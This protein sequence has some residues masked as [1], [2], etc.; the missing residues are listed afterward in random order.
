MVWPT[1]GS[2]TA[3]KQNRTEQNLPRCF[4]EM[5]MVI[6]RSLLFQFIQ[7]R[8]MR[9]IYLPSEQQLQC[10]R[11]VQA[12]ALAPNTPTQPCPSERIR[13][14]SETISF[15]RYVKTNFDQYFNKMTFCNDMFNGILSHARTVVRECCK[16][17]QQS[18]WEMLKF[19]PQLPLN[20]FG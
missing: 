17:D 15:M 18:Q 5:N 8:A 13:L 11:A 20:R 1:V 3:K 14:I 12:R 10:R 6:K 7:L 9:I 19:D 4:H 16:D 2:T